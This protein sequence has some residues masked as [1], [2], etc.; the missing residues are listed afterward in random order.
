MGRHYKVKNA[1]EVGQI[2][3]RAGI[4][5]QAIKAVAEFDGSYKGAME[6]CGKLVVLADC[7]TFDDYWSEQ[8]DRGTY[9]MANTLHELAEAKARE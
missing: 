3:G 6:L 1:R 5:E 7:A 9:K 8:V 4:S 2:L